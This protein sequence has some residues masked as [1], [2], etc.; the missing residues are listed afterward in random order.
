MTISS[1]FSKKYGPWALVTGASSGIGEQFARELA[2]RKLHLFLVARRAE[3]LERLAQELAKAHG[4][5]AEPIPLDLAQ[6]GFLETLQSAVREREVG[7][8]VSNAGFGL[9]GAFQ[10]QDPERLCAM[11][12]VNGR[13]PL[14]LLHAFIPQLLARGRGGLVLTGSVEGFLPF[15]W[16]TAYAATKAF[17]HSL[18]EGLHVELESHGVDVLVVAPGPTDTEALTLQGFKPEELPGIMTPA[19]VARAALEQLGRRAVFVPGWLNRLT[20]GLLRRLP[21]KTAARLLGANMRAAI[22]KRH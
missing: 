12:E 11:L 3:R 1:E 7:L 4:I 9:K 8:I 15:P 22:E 10:E 17:V 14:L 5:Q 20:F 6:A 21:R 16:S 2:A 13:A 19:Q 18:G